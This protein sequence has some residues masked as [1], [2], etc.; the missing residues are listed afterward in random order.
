MLNGSF[1]SRSLV[2]FLPSLVFPILLSKSQIS[3]QTEYLFL[4]LIH[5][6]SEGIF[7]L[8]SGVKIGESVR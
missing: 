4:Y 7:T 2:F 8:K 6:D 1:V 5:F 3:I